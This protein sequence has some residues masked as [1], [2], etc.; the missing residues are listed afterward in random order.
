MKW[1]RENWF[2]LGIL[3]ALLLVAASPAYYFFRYL[4]ETNAQTQADN[5]FVQAYRESELQTCLD[6][7]D[8]NYSQIFDA[9][10]KLEGNSNCDT[11]PTLSMTTVLDLQKDRDNQKNFCFQ[12]YPQ[13]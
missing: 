10:C 6:K 11:N 2:K 13:N 3:A 1:A 7:A 5:A 12:Q 9:D 8:S 4:P